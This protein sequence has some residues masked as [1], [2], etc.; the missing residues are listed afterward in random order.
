MPWPRHLDD[1]LTSAK[2]RLRTTLA[3]R[4]PAPPS[5]LAAPPEAQTPGGAIAFAPGHTVSVWGTGPAASAA[6]VGDARGAPYAGAAPVVPF[7][8]EGKVVGVGHHPERGRFVVVQWPPPYGTLRMRPDDLVNAQ[9]EHERAWGK[10]ATPHRGLRAARRTLIDPKAVS[11]ETV[12]QHLRQFGAIDAPDFVSR[13]SWFAGQARVRQLPRDEVAYPD[14]VTAYAKRDPSTMP[15]VVL[16]DT[17]GQVESVDGTHRIAAARVARWTTVPAYL[18]VLP[19]GARLIA[20][21]VAPRPGGPLL[22]AWVSPDGAV[23]GGNQGG[24]HDEWMRR[25]HR[26]LGVPAGPGTPYERALRAGWVRIGEG[27]SIEVWAVTSANVERILALARRLAALGA[28]AGVIAVEWHEPSFDSTTLQVIEG[29]IATGSQLELRELA[30][31]RAAGLR[32]TA[33]IRGYHG[34][35][36]GFGE[37]DPNKSGLGTHFGTE[38]AA[39]ERREKHQTGGADWEIRSFDLDVQNPLRMKDIWIWD[40]AERVRDQLYFR[41]VLLLRDVA[42]IEAGQPA[43]EVLRAA[44]ERAGYDCIVYR[45]ETEGGGDDSYIV[46]RSEKIR[47]VGARVT[48]DVVAPTLYPG[49][50]EPAREQS[51]VREIAYGLKVQDPVSVAAAAE[52]MADLVPPGAVLVPVP[53]SKGS[54]AAN[55]ILAEAIAKRTGATVADVLTGPVRESLRVRRVRDRADL[56]IDALGTTTRTAPPPGQIVLID[57]VAITGATGLAAERALGRAVTLLTWAAAAA[58]A[59]RRLSST[60]VTAVR[61]VATAADDFR[62]VERYVDT[63]AFFTFSDVPRFAARPV[64]ATYG[65]TPHGF[66]AYPLTRATF[67][68]WRQDYSEVQYATERQWLLIWRFKPGARVTDVG[69]LQAPWLAYTEGLIDEAVEGIRSQLEDIADAAEADA[70]DE[71]AAIRRFMDNEVSLSD[72]FHAVVTHRAD[73]QAVFSWQ[74]RYAAADSLEGAVHEFVAQGAASAGAGGALYKALFLASGRDIVEFA[75]RLR[76]DLNLQGLI[77]DGSGTIHPNEPAQAVALDP[78]AVE[79]LATVRNPMAAGTDTAGAA[80]QSPLEAFRRAVERARAGAPVDALAV[81]RAHA[82]IPSDPT[83]L[84]ERLDDTQLNDLA[85]THPAPNMR[86]YVERVQHAREHARWEAAAEPLYAAVA[87]A[88]IRNDVVAV[89]QLVRPLTREQRDSLRWHLQQQ[90]RSDAPGARDAF[91]NYRDMEDQFPTRAGLRVQADRLPGGRGDDLPD[92]DFDPDALARGVEDEQEHTN[93]PALARE[94]AKDH[95]VQDPHYYTQAGLRVTADDGLADPA[96]I[97][98]L[99][100]AARVD[101]KVVAAHLGLWTSGGVWIDRD[102][103]R[104]R[105]FHVD[106]PVAALPRVRPWDVAR[107]Q[108][109]A[110]SDPAT[111]P[112]IV[113][114][115]KLDN[116]RWRLEILDGEH[117][118]HAARLAKW[119]TVPAFVGFPD[120]IRWTDNTQASLRVAAVLPRD[121]VVT[122][123]RARLDAVHAEEAE[124]AQR[125]NAGEQGIQYYWQLGRL[126]RVQ[127]RR[128][129]FVWDGAVRAYHDVTG[130]ADN[131][132]YMDP[133]IHSVDPVPMHGF[134]G[135]RYY[136]PKQAGLHTTGRRTLRVTAAATFWRLQQAKDPLSTSWQSEI[137]DGSGTEAATS[138]ARSL[139]DLLAWM[140]SGN[141]QRWLGELAFIEFVGDE[142]GRGADGEPVVRPKQE[143]QR[144]TLD[145]D[146][147][148]KW[149]ELQAAIRQKRVRD[150]ATLRAWG[151]IRTPT[152]EVQAAAIGADG[153]ADDFEPGDLTGGTFQI[154]TDQHHVVRDEPPDPQPGDRFV[155]FGRDDRGWEY[156]LRFPDGTLGSW[157]YT[158]SVDDLAAGYVQPVAVRVAR[159]MKPHAELTWHDL[160]VV[161]EALSGETRGKRSKY[162][163]HVDPQHFGSPAATPGAGRGG[164]GYFTGYTAE[165]GDSLDVLWG[166]LPERRSTR[167]SEPVWLFE[168]VDFDDQTHRQWKVAVAFAD[169]ASARA[170][171]LALWPPEMLGVVVE[172]NAR[173]FLHKHLPLLSPPSTREVQACSTP[174]VRVVATDNPYEPPRTYE[175]AVE[176]WQNL[177]AELGVTPYELGHL[178]WTGRATP[179][180]VALYQDLEELDLL[181]DASRR[182]RHNA[183]LYRASDQPDGGRWWSEDVEDARAY[184]DNPGFGGSTL[185]QIPQPRE[186]AL[187]WTAESPESIAEAFGRDVETFTATYHHVHDILDGPV[188]DEELRAELRGQGYVWVRLIDT[189]PEGATSWFYLGDDPP[190]GKPVQR[191][192]MR[193]HTGAAVGTHVL[194][195]DGP[196]RTTEVDED[197]GGPDER[198]HV[199]L[200]TGANHTYPTTDLRVIAELAGQVHVAA[201]LDPVQ[202]WPDAEIREHLIDHVRAQMHA[203]LH[204]T[205]RDLLQLPSMALSHVRTALANV[206]RLLNA[207]LPRARRNHTDEEIQERAEQLLTGMWATLSPTFPTVPWLE[208]QLGLRLTALRSAVAEFREAAQQ[209]VADWPVAVYALEIAGTVVAL[210]SREGPFD[211]AEMF[212]YYRVDE[213]YDETRYAVPFTHAVL[214]PDAALI[215]KV[216]TTIDFEELT[217]RL[218]VYPRVVLRSV[219]HIDPNDREACLRVTAGQVALRPDGYQTYRGTW[220]GHDVCIRGEHAVVPGAYP[221]NRRQRRRLTWRVLLDGEQIATAD[222]LRDAKTALDTYVT[223]ATRAA[224]RAAV[225]VVAMPMPTTLPPGWRLDVHEDLHPQPAAIG[226]D[227]VYFTLSDE[228]AQTVAEV[229]ISRWTRPGVWQATHAQNY[230]PAEGWGAYVLQKALEYVSARDEYLATS[231]HVSE[232]AARVMDKMLARPDIEAVDY[233]TQ[234]RVRRNEPGG[235]LWDPKARPSL[236]KKYRLKASLDT[237]DGHDG[238]RRPWAAIDLDGTLLE[239]PTADDYAAA[240]A[241]GT[242]PRL[243]APLPGAAAGVQA[244]RDAGW[245]TSVFTARFS[246]ELDDDTRTAWALEILDHL[247][248]H[249]IHVDDVWIG[250]DK[251]RTD[252]F[253]DDKAVAFTGDWATAVDYARKHVAAAAHDLPDTLFHGTR[254]ANVTTLIPSTGGEFGPGAYL[255]DFEPTAALFAQRAVGPDA[256]T[257]LEVRA[258]IRN[259]F[260]VTK[261]EWLRLTTTSTPRTVQR[262]LQQKGHD[263]IIGIAVN[264]YER[265]IVVFDPASIQVIGRHVAGLRVMAGDVRPLRGP[266]VTI[267]GRHYVLSTDGGPLGDRRDDADRASTLPF[268]GGG[269]RLVLPA[270]PGDPYRYLWVLVTDTGAVAMWRVSDGNLKVVSDARAEA[271]RVRDLTARREINR[272]TQAEYTAIDADM[273][274]RADAELAD[275]EQYIRDNEG[276]FQK[277]VNEATR[278][279]FAT[280]VVPHIE[281]GLAALAAGAVPIGFE[282]FGPGVTDPRARARQAQTH[283]VEQAVMRYFALPALEDWLR[284]QGLDVNAPGGDI[285]AAYWAHGDTYREA[286]DQYVGRRGASVRVVAVGSPNVFPVADRLAADLA[287]AI[288]HEAQQEPKAHIND[289]ASR[290]IRQVGGGHTLATL[291]PKGTLRVPPADALFRDVLLVL[292]PTASE[293]A[294]GTFDP[295]NSGLI[296]VF[297]SGIL[298]RLP[299]AQHASADAVRARLRTT[300]A[301]ELVHAADWA[302]QSA[303]RPGAFESKVVNYVPGDY[304]ET[305]HGGQRA[306]RGLPKGTDIRIEEMDRVRGRVTVHITSTPGASGIKQTFDIRELTDA[307]RRN[308]LR[309]FRYTPEPAAGE[310]WTRT[311]DYANRPTELLAHVMNAADVIWRL[312]GPRWRSV[313]PTG[314]DIYAFIKND[315]H[316]PFW[317]IHDD[318][319]RQ[320]FVARVVRELERRTTAAT[321][322]AA[323]HTAMLR[324][325]ADDD[326]RPNDPRLPAR[327]PTEP[328]LADDVLEGE[329]LPGTPPTTKRTLTPQDLVQPDRGYRNIMNVLG[330]ATASEV[331]YWGRWYRTAHEDVQALAAHY[332]LPFDVV[333]GVVAVL[334]PG[335]SWKNNL[336]VAEQVLQGK[337]TGLSAYPNAVQK[338]LRVLEQGDPATA[339]NARTPKTE[340]FYRS[341]IDPEGTAR[342]V[343]NMVIDGHAINIWRG[344]AAARL[345]GI[346]SPTRDEQAAM[347]RDYARAARAF[348]LTPQGVQA[349]TWAV[350]QSLAGKRFMVAA[351]DDA[352]WHDD[353]GG[354]GYDRGPVAD[355]T[356]DPAVNGVTIAADRAAAPAVRVP[357]DV[358]D[359]ACPHCKDIIHERFD[360]RHIGADALGRHLVEHRCGGLFWYPK[361]LDEAAAQQDF[362]ARFGSVR[363]EAA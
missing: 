50:D 105:W 111:A 68:A 290:A 107:A 254:H 269:G 338:A 320:D 163:Q 226:K 116:D 325:V 56:S 33:G 191:S 82:V 350:W 17:D 234:R 62:T 129:Y 346:R 143:L 331:D 241:S 298:Q 109:F 4:A 263:A 217:A 158:N 144:W 308:D 67:D 297:V 260:V 209:A 291:F 328:D 11:W 245:Q 249:G 225:R 261:Q 276:D 19:D 210:S 84:L 252:V 103:V 316:P 203:R 251:P 78:T 197:D 202:M 280:H 218:Q 329:R 195:P 266:S 288:V 118:V 130:M 122:I 136:E 16:V 36:G 279:Y 311:F 283:V 95:L 63:G 313:L 72:L 224:Q 34:T 93:D 134:R 66:Y 65:T 204:T 29:S 230:R 58:V 322:A 302:Y 35:P 150:L 142:V 10:D 25:F 187:D 243:G 277:R 125:T 250:K 13:L 89:Q 255:T 198:M 239:S 180:A 59:G 182:R 238:P 192:G 30:R 248:Q 12:A 155:V 332:A 334:S 335:N 26:V 319:A 15:P 47:R 98:W 341:I 232:D 141:E 170:A 326:F 220:E 264:G 273:R 8:T 349:V 190:E 333:A 86:G 347:R 31:G 148:Q 219:R 18:G 227:V 270:D 300:I 222:R 165:D 312:H 275:L 282:P 164:M 258:T 272:V 154:V 53:D 194:T 193:Q 324:V 189:F 205:E 79:P 299:K 91:I 80:R 55:R 127:P 355:P 262:R 162:P 99:A 88:A 361:T 212:P 131:R 229:T 94:I 342:D 14:D 281:E 184:L 358:Y 41:G 362:L 228:H 256:P 296:T 44:I 159:D 124:V 43:W 293:T 183:A 315:A 235:G 357:R 140:I 133:T 173:D 20:G 345:K 287:D 139:E 271:D 171:F 178:V 246:A 339:F 46:W 185:Y 100:G 213:P 343:A 5:G 289:V 137:A 42:A 23:Y 310:N 81:L 54:T 37:L 267:G 353:A 40:D 344:D 211:P 356:T 321:P 186:P 278:Q 85:D 57:N 113:V 215:D 64:G 206:I 208:Q 363:V 285:Q 161:L 354:V 102:Y 104:G 70:P 166:P 73:L 336:E 147:L 45:N 253:I 112:E 244:L 83:A 351:P 121:I 330:Q 7:N 303:A 69:Q 231:D 359:F 167:W 145:L 120:W 348:G 114:E 6:A 216:L 314:K 200:D 309:R 123:P 236:W 201:V 135:F 323:P 115:A 74:N 160:P 106:I 188:P 1:L 39:Q 51:R 108:E 101:Y 352:P 21:A 305:V 27:D 169:V 292:V 304:F 22:G 286:L 340:R 175:R 294:F 214:G 247:A 149:E 307:V 237:I 48:A 119:P 179:E 52:I 196:G 257:V 87:A 75:R 233:A 176:R 153:D 2:E 174:G 77:D 221:G 337:R 301:H 360:G 207:H 306:F 90:A 295:S 49:R 259:P 60:R 3:P 168:Q 265:Q 110:T 38:R 76:D 61:V 240:Q 138:A 128:I 157:G 146:T 268:G 151:A 242:Q 181:R 318:R 274:A 172:T 97:S 126:P 223:N 9:P 152:R 32:V 24:S 71:A 156:D 28:H 317:M 92:Q 199:V 132:V 327:R 117:R 177:A 96:A 284:T